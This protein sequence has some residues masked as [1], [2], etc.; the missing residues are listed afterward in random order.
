MCVIDIQIGRNSQQCVYN[1]FLHILNSR[2]SQNVAWLIEQV[3]ML[4]QLVVFY[5]KH[6]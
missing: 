1:I 6:M 2:N 4:Y 3:K 5:N